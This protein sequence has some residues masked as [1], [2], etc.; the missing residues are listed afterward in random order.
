MRT[1][2][3]KGMGS[4][5]FQLLSDFSSITDWLNECINCSKLL[6]NVIEK[7]FLNEWSARTGKKF[8]KEYTKPWLFIFS[9]FSVCRK[10]L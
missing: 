2:K 10:E 6:E 5:T 9:L 8:W 7:L 1:A 3:V 4:N